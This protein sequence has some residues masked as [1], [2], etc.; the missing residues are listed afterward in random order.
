MYI[1]NVLHLLMG[2]GVEA[3]WWMLRKRINNLQL[4][5]ERENRRFHEE[6]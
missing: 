3:V 1:Y 5:E 2:Q 4:Q 6:G